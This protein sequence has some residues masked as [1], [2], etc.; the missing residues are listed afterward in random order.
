MEK[1]K[2]KEKEEREPFILL[3]ASKLGTNDYEGEAFSRRARCPRVE[4]IVLVWVWRACVDLLSFPVYYRVQ[5]VSL[6]ASAGGFELSTRIN[7]SKRGHQNMQLFVDRLFT[8][9]E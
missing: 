5:Q 4:H 2:K 9:V 3:C 1:K 8:T 7:H 6:C